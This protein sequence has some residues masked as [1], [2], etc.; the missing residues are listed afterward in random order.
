MSFSATLDSSVAISASLRR[1][2]FLFVWMMFFLNAV[3][4]KEPAPCDLFM[5]MF[6]I[7]MPLFGLVRFTAIH[8]LMFALLMIVIAGGLIAAGTHEFYI[9]SAKHMLI[10]L[11]LSI[12]AVV[13][14][15]FI[16][17]NPGQHL[18]LVWN[19]YM[20]GAI[21]AAVAGIIGYFDLIPGS[22]DL[23]TK[24]GRARG[25]FKDPNV[26][27]PYL[28]PAFLYCLHRLLTRDANTGLV[29]IG[30][31]G[32]FLFGI[33]MCFSRG[34]WM[35]FCI[36]SASYVA[37]FV[38]TAPNSR[39]RL[40]I[41]GLCVASLIVL[42]GVLAVA[43]QSPKVQE[44]WEERA[45]LKQTHD[46]GDQGRFAGHKKAMNVIL[47]NP[48][49]IGALYFGYYYH[50]ELPHNV[51]LSMFLSTGWIGGVV[52]LILML[53][54][55]YFGISVILYRAPW[56]HYHAI[57]VCTFFGLLIE[58]YIVDT[59]H[60]RLLYILMGLIWGAFAYVKLE[61]HQLRTRNH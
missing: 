21:I 12:F 42:I 7:L 17:R 13:L 50:H 51:Y 24:Y 41:F 27:G 6:V 15:A 57:A 34:A 30:L 11:Y 18:E 47:E 10:S 60:W 45:T 14:A 28:V 26:F 54:T 20:C 25:T 59:D 2:L 53:T 35:L 48:V 55:L 39:Q 49:G 1:L 16:T 44:L 31:M 43:L 37:V 22:F 40:K 8:G 3:V 33:L 29:S 38:L 32:L 23:F 58:N 56:T 19:G 46:V 4:I 36:A 9:V 61:E 52:F 5:M